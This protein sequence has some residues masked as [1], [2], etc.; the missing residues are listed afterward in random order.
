MTAATWQSLGGDSG[1]NDRGAA[2]GFGAGGW[3]LGS[4][5]AKNE[6]QLN[7]PKFN[8]FFNSTFFAKKMVLHWFY[9]EKTKFNPTEI[10]LKLQL[11]VLGGAG[12]FGKSF[13]ICCC[14]MVRF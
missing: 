11:N 14:L 1:E 13:P 3:G 9:N 5:G 12:G 8:P 7:G 10:Q 4:F 6:I 2:L